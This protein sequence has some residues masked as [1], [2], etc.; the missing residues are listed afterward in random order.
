MLDGAGWIPKKINE[1]ARGSS[2]I[3]VLPVYTD[4]GFRAEYG[5]LFAETNIL[6]TMYQTEWNNFNPFD[7]TYSIGAGISFK[8]VTMG[9]KHTC[10]HPM[11]AYSLYHNYRLVNATE[12]SMNNMYV[13]ID[14]K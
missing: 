5:I 13:R 11:Q 4:L 3:T 1:P 10:Y 8:G 12:G 6:T 2:L 14:I 9:I 7:N